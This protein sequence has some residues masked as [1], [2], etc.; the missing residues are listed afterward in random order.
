MKEKTDQKR[1][2]PTELLV[3]RLQ[4]IE[5]IHTYDVLKD[6]RR[7]VVSTTTVCQ[8]HETAEAVR[9]RERSILWGIDHT[10]NHTFAPACWVDFS[11]ILIKHRFVP[12]SWVYFSRK[13]IALSP[14]V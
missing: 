7:A 4:M 10:K 2:N 5:H 9:G 12:V 11:P 13:S 6:G 14:G 3:G 8:V 1:D